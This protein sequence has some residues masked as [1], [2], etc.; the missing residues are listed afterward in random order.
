MFNTTCAFGMR[1]QIVFQSC[2]NG[3][4]LYKPD[5][6]HIAYLSGLDNGICPPDHPVQLPTLFLETLWAVANVPDQTPQGRFVFSQGDPTG[7]GFHAD[8]QNGWDSAVLAG[9]VRDCLVPDN[10]G[11]ISYCPYLQASQSSGYPYNCPEMPPQIGEPVKGLIDKLPGCINIT[12]GPNEAPAASMNCAPGVPLPSITSTQDS[13]PR[14]TASPVYGQPFG[15]PQQQYLGCFNDSTV[16]KRTLNSIQTSDYTAMTVEYCQTY[17]MQNGYRLSG[18][19]YTQECHC[20]NLLNPTAVNGSNQCTWNCGG[21]MTTGTGKQELCGGIGYISVFNNTDATFNAFGDMSNTAGTAQK[22]T[23]PS[24][25]ASNYLGC[26]SDNAGSGRTLTGPNLN[27]QN[28]MTIEACG[29]F[30]SQGNNGI[31]YQYYGL[32]FSTQCEHQYVRSLMRV[33]AD[34]A[35]GWCGNS[36]ANGG[37][38]LTP[39]SSP[40]NDTCSMR[41]AGNEPDICGGPAVLS[42][43]NSTAYVSPRHKPSIGKYKPQG[44]LL[45]PNTNG[46]ALQGASIQDPHMTEEKCVKYCLGRSYR[47]AG[48]E[49]GAECYCGNQ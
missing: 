46:R 33:L 6:S 22:Y 29:A 30:C 16:G 21:T 17:C 42:L 41:C 15:L 7:Y 49:Y 43:Y 18:V 45:D 35:L 11:Q 14:P 36:I 38:L 3:V 47:Y 5:N 1:A 34:I 27:L 39:T 20:D 13:V 24:P 19:E 23:P 48:M 44:C 9:A 8:F 37:I 2:W 10:F 26:Y 40:T 4:D 25:F 28:N 31:G 32:E 12:D